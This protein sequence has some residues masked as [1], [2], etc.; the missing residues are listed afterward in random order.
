MMKG[1]ITKVLG[2][3]WNTESD[4]LSVSTKKFNANEPAT[5]KREVLATIASIYDPLGLISPTIIKLKTFLQELWQREMEWDDPLNETD[6]ERWKALTKDLKE[7]STIQVPRFIGDKKPQLLGFCDASKNAYAAAIYLRTEIDG[8][9]HVNLIFSKTRNAPKEK[10]VNN[11]EKQKDNSKNKKT[12][13]KMTIPRLELMSTL[14]GTRSLRFI[15][16]ELGLQDKQM[17]LW[18]DSQCVLD[19]LKQKENSDVFV[20]NRVKEITSENDVVFRYVNTKHNPADIPTRGMTTEELKKSDLW[21]HG[22]E[23]LKEDADQWPT[24]NIDE[25]SKETI[26]KMLESDEKGPKILYE[27]SMPAHTTNNNNQS[28]NLSNHFLEYH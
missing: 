3:Q 6:K 1:D 16:K 25:V 12:K 7:L 2:L 15:A 9:S 19:W 13:E 28:I 10:K 24:W 14:I 23:W 20:R 4:K 22:P 8:K 27:T 17:I 21:W 26:A 18:T 11:K 5:T